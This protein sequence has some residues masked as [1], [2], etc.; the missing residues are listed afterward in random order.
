M[1]A[2]HEEHCCWWSRWML[3]KMKFSAVAWACLLFAAGAAEGLPKLHQTSGRSLAL[4]R[5]HSS[6]ARIPSSRQLVLF[7]STLLPLGCDTGLHQ[8]QTTSSSSAQLRQR[9]QILRQ[10]FLSTDHIPKLDSHLQIAG[11]RSGSSASATSARHHDS[12][13]R[14]RIRYDRHL[15]QRGRGPAQQSERSDTSSCH[16]KR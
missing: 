4:L 6:Q 12:H 2:A 1:F 16:L 5:K 7:S 13:N 15:Q 14:R 9:N 3:E 10:T 11:E 8:I